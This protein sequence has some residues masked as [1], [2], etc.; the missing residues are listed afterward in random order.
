[1]LYWVKFVACGAGIIFCGY[2][3]SFLADVICEKTS[4]TRTIMGFAILAIATSA[5]EFVTS[6]ASVAIVKAPDFALGD[7]FGS[8]IINLGI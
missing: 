2:R 3:L 8:I 1:M 6:G 7:V 4:V 5:P